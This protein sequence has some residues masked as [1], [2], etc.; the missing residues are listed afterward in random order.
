MRAGMIYDSLQ[1]IKTSAIR[2]GKFFAKIWKKI[3]DVLSG[4]DIVEQYL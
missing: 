4:F 1:V 2:D 3:Y